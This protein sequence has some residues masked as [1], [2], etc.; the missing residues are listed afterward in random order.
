[1]MNFLPGDTV[2][3]NCDQGVLWMVRATRQMVIDRKKMSTIFDRLFADKAGAD[4][5]NV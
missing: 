2:L 1:M 5:R 4:G 3:M